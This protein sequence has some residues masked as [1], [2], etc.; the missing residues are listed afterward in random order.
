MDPVTCVLLEIFL[1]CTG[2]F[3]VTYGTADTLVSRIL[4][5]IC[6]II[7]MNIIAFRIYNDA[8]KPK[9]ISKFA[10]VSEAKATLTKFTSLPVASDQMIDTMR[11]FPGGRKLLLQE[12]YDMLDSNNARHMVELAAGFFTWDELS[13]AIIAK[14]MEKNTMGSNQ[15]I[16]ILLNSDRIALIFKKQLAQNAA[17]HFVN[18]C[19]DVQNLMLSDPKDGF[20]LE[21]IRDFNYQAAY[22]LK[23]CMDFGDTDTF[24]NGDFQSY[25][26]TLMALKLK[27]NRPDFMPQDSDMD[28]FVQYY[29]QCV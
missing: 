19:E 15:T 26:A 9:Q 10:Y 17:L 22:C 11:N 8:P 5:A 27:S 24:L 18:H 25:L 6:F 21:R 28:I 3:L 14:A 2:G 12:A 4:I 20:V 7:W 23:Y 13:D 1:S 29:A 16:S